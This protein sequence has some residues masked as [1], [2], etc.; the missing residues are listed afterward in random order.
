MRVLPSEK[1]E[2]LGFDPERLALV[3]KLIQKLVEVGCFPGAVLLAARRGQVVHFKAFGYAQLYPER[4]PTA[5]DTVFDLASLTKVVA[6]TPVILRLAEMGELSLDDPVSLYFPAF[7]EGSK[8]R[9][10]ISHLLTHT[11]GLPAY[12][13]LYS[14]LGHREDVYGYIAGLDLEYEPGTKVVYSD[15]GF[16]LLGRIAELVADKPLDELARELV[17]EPLGMRETAYNPPLELRE[18]AAATEYCRLRGRILRGEVHDENAWFMGGVAGHAGLF[19]TARDLALYAQMWL[20]KGSLTARVLSPATVEL[21]TRNHT[22]GLNE[23]RGLGWALNCRPC[24]CGDFMS[25][26]AYGHTGFTGTSLWIDPAYELSVTLLTN[27]VHP[28]RENQCLLR[29]RRLIHNAVMA[30]LAEPS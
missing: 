28:T 23:C 8:K 26:R 2:R 9:V 6:T 22:Q 18:R 12:A 5:P 10:T 27:R 16:I 15:L 30:S 20:N 7:S 1:P 29:A 25:P 11:S 17:F 3:D 19:S 14:L 13:P 4:R 24:S 21:A